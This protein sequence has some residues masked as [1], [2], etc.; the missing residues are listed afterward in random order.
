MGQKYQI[1][2]EQNAQRAHASCEP[3]PLTVSVLPALQPCRFRCQDPSATPLVTDRVT[4]RGIF[5]F[6]PFLTLQNISD[7]DLGLT[8]SLI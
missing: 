6:F 3:L 8:W 4:F 2:D 1:K 7:L 5:I